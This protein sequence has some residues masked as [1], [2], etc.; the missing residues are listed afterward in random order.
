DHITCPEYSWK[1][2][3]FTQDASVLE[4]AIQQTGIGEHDG[5]LHVVAAMVSILTLVSGIFIMVG[6]FTR[7]LSYIQIV[8]ISLGLAFIYTTG[9]H[10]NNFEVISTI[11]IVSLLVFIANKGS[12]P[13]S[14]DRA[15]EGITSEQTDLKANLKIE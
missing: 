11:I 10:R 9:I 1:G 15:I 2:L 4:A 3:L 13:I 12:G 6:L 14:F 7:L 5:F 8:V